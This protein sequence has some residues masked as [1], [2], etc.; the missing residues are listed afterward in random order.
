MPGYKSTSTSNNSLV[1]IPTFYRYIYA[2]PGPAI[3]T[4]I[5][6]Y[7]STTNSTSNLLLL[8]TGNSQPLLLLKVLYDRYF[9]L[10][11][12]SNEYI[13]KTFEREWICNFV[14]TA[15]QWSLRIS[16]KFQPFPT[17]P[18]YR[19]GISIFQSQPKQVEA[20]DNLLQKNIQ[21]VWNPTGTS[22]SPHLGKNVFAPTVF[23]LLNLNA[24][25]MI[26]HFDPAI[27][28]HQFCF[29]QNWWL[30][31]AGCGRTVV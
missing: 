17:I 19:C 21:D 30:P 29:L 22:N 6:K 3:F 20:D 8:H 10:K 28:F 24:N 15:K 16:Q 4:E 14:N 31:I 27:H 18:T 1:W 25:F 26:P 9:K 13:T 7:Y 5:V 12:T 23:R 11:L 2:V